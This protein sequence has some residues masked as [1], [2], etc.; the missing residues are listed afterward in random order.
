MNRIRIIAALFAALL[1]FSSCASDKNDKADYRDEI[2]ETVKES[3]S[4]P[5]DTDIQSAEKDEGS[6]KEEAADADNEAVTDEK[7]NSLINPVF[8]HE[9]GVYGESVSLE[10]NIPEGASGVASIRYTTDGNE[11]TAKSPKYSEPIKLLAAKE[12][13]VVRA[14]CFSRNGQ[15]LG[16][17]VTNTYVKSGERYSS[18]MVVS[19]TCDE[20]YLYDARTGIW[21]NPTQHGKAWERPSHVEFFTQ[22]GERVIDQDAGLRIFGGSSRVLEQKSFRIIARK[23]AY[24]DD[25]RYN[26]EGKFKY[27]I[28]DNAADVNGNVLEAFDRLV[29]R[30]G[31]NDSLQSVAADPQQMN[32]L[33]D[34]IVNNFAVR[35]ADAVTSQASRLVT[36]ILNGKYYGILDLK[37]DPDDNFISSYYGIEQKDNITIIKSELDTTRHCSKHSNGGECR[38]CN[39]WFYYEVDSGEESELESLTSLLKKAC[40]ATDSNYSDVYKEIEGKIDV[41]NFMQ[42]MALNLY[43]CNTDWPHNNIRLWRYNGEYVEGQPYTDG[44]WRFTTR[45]ED[46]AFGR[47]KCEVL[48]EIYTMAD[49][50]TFARMLANYWNGSYEYNAS[51]GYYPDSLLLQGLGSFLMRND[52]FRSEFEAYCRYL[53]NDENI[54]LLRSL[55]EDYAAQCRPLIANHIKQLSGTI[56]GGYS[57]SK[58]EKAVDNMYSWLDERPAYFIEY[59]EQMLSHYE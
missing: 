33:R 5:D 19:I 59:M 43:I 32:L 26:G 31:G 4:G 12:S 49:T 16:N 22:N 35:T 2:N 18:S 44:K 29:L 54:A 10:L 36:V 38:F 8:S 57:V 47:Y 27:H 45:D 23:T 15:L 39:V 14:A 58:W 50:N 20:N 30:N 17:V 46:F 56:D 42:Y 13:V 55:M 6:G 37:E 53:V 21:V 48:P 51:T 34:G 3:S 52:T 9:G 40:S 1:I 28:F 24:F 11:P 7:E 25:I 41:R